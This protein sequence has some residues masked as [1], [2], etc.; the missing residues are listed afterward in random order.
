MARRLEGQIAV[1]T[2]GTSGIGVATAKRFAAEGARV[3]VTGR[4]SA[5]LD[6]AVAAI[7]PRA[8]GIQAD[9]AS[10]S[11]LNRLYE[12]VK[13]DAGRIDV[14]FVN[15]GGGSMLPLGSI[16]EGQYDDTFGRNVKGVLFT[17]QKALPLLVDG[18]SVI[19]TASNVSIKGT[20]AFSVYSASKA[21][22]RNFARSW[23]LDLKARGIRVNVISPGPIKTPGLVG[24]AGSDAAQQQSLLDY[25]ASTVPLGRVGDPDDVAGAAVFLASDDAS[26]IAG[27]ELFVD[28]GQAQI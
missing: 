18:A 15:A 3:F 14:L 19:L 8:T 11:D 26:F 7:G 27:A 22:V 6:A 25:M 9:S 24:L 12:R 2:G 21:A 17:V 13:V 20:P 5:E 4:R 28:G 23:T 1:V 10:L 16:T